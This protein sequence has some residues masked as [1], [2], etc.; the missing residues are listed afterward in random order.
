M[1]G[2]PTTTTIPLLTLLV[3]L[4]LPACSRQGAMEQRG[5]VPRP[6]TVVHQ[7]YEAVNDYRADHDLP[8]LKLHKGIAPVAQPHTDGMAAG[9]IPFSHNNSKERFAR[10]MEMFDVRR[11][12]E[13]LAWSTPRPDVAQAIVDI[14]IESTKGHRETLLGPYRLTGIA[15][16]VGRD[17][18]FYAT[19][20]F[21]QEQDGV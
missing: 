12:A 13:N 4:L 19:Q 1:K 14:W 2:T 3:A 21:V 10:L 11:V 16:A 15:V 9:T 20:M 7:I 18:R 6:E 8:P 5:N 17:G